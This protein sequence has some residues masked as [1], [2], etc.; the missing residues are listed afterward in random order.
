MYQQ[1]SKLR[2]ENQLT[3]L[4]ER[5]VSQMQQLPEE[6]FNLDALED[7]G[8]LV[9]VDS[10]TDVLEQIRAMISSGQL[11]QA[12]SA[13]D[14]LQDQVNQ[15]LEQI[16]DSQE[17]G[18]GTISELEQQL[19][20][21]LGELE[22]IALQEQEVLEAT[23]NLQ[24]NVRA[25]NLESALEALDN[26]IAPLNNRL[27]SLEDDLVEAVIGLAPNLFYGTGIPASILVLRAKGAK[28]EER[29]GKVL[30]I[31]AD[32]EYYEG[33]AQ[34]HLL[35]EHIEKIASTFE[36]FAQEP[37][38]SRVVPIAELLVQGEQ[39]VQEFRLPGWIAQSLDRSQP[40]LRIRRSQSDTKFCGASQFSLRAPNL[41]LDYII[42]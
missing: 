3:T 36:A 6:H 11:N 32:R 8:M 13:L 10:M 14:N 19:G 17:G 27:N 39:I 37:G 1:N 12:L 9:D 7:M 20:E 25:R 30:F 31:N 4:L 35:P 33:R 5:L 40:G 18:T 29:Q 42:D 24:E 15:L 34:N 22:D 28:P 21:L 23:Q 38:F 16:M 41:H 26:A 2:L